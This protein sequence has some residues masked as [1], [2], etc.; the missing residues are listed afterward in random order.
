MNLWCTHLIFP[1]S[2]LAG[3]FIS[4]DAENCYSCPVNNTSSSPAGEPNLCIH[5]LH[6][7]ESCIICAVYISIHFLP[8]RAEY[9]QM[10]SMCWRASLSIPLLSGALSS[11]LE[12]LGLIVLCSS[13]AHGGALPPPDG[14][15]WSA[16]HWRHRLPR[17]SSFSSLI[18]PLPPTIR[19][20]EWFPWCKRQVACTT[21]G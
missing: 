17:G 5:S 11:A 14:C 12:V 18:L 8:L 19:A 13:Q 10:M 9:A 1:Q 16:P 4:R 20:E 2:D 7:R 15:M 6:L 21:S 3:L